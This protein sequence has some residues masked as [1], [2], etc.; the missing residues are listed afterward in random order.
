MHKN[1]TYSILLILTLTQQD[2]LRPRTEIIPQ[3][4]LALGTTFW[5]GNWDCFFG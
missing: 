1:L 2:P 4:V 3:A 5:R